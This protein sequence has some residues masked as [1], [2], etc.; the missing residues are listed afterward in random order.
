L[1]GLKYG[2][3]KGQEKGEFL[4]HN[5]NYRNDDELCNF[6]T[7]EMF[8]GYCG[9]YG[10]MVFVHSHYQCPRCKN[11]IAPCCEGENTNESDDK[12]VENPPQNSDTILSSDSP[13]ETK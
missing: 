10:E 1:Y 13:E 9:Y 3:N 4:E 7:M 11:N 6:V 8:C 12:E 2:N 5:A